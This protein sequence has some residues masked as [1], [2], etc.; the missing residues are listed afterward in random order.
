VNAIATDEENVMMIKVWWQKNRTWL[1]SV[2]VIFALGFAGYKYYTNEQTKT[3]EQASLLF[4]E[5]FGAY[6]SGD[7]ETAMTLGT[8]IQTDHPHTP[9]ANSVAL[10]FAQV[11]ANA[12]DLAKTAEHLTWI[13]DKGPGFAKDIAKVRLAQVKLAQ[14]EGDAAL[15]LLNRTAADSYQP[16][17]DEVKGDVLVSMQRYKDA[18]VAYD[19]A[20]QGY[21]ELG[22]Q[23]HL[24]E[25][26]MDALPHENS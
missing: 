11:A 24:L 5:F 22:F 12:N 20:L 15:A 13:V 2:I 1:L 16:L 10:L 17:Y 23:T 3:A 4:T 19:A 9:Y 7:M 8:Q 26:K 6:E 18:R 14:G 25:F 21:T